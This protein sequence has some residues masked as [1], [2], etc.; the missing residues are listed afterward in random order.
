MELPGGWPTSPNAAATGKA[1]PAV[2]LNDSGACDAVL[3]GREPEL[4]NPGGVGPWSR[5]GR[6]AQGSFCLFPRMNRPWCG[7]TTLSTR[8]RCGCVSTA[9]PRSSRC[10]ERHGQRTDGDGRTEWV[11]GQETELGS[12]STTWTSSLCGLGLAS[13]SGQRQEAGLV[14]IPVPG[15]RFDSWLCPLTSLGGGVGEGSCYNQVPKPGGLQ[16]Q[17]FTLSAWRPGLKARCVWGGRPPESRRGLP[18]PPGSLLDGEIGS[19]AL[20]C[21]PLLRGHMALS[22]CVC[23]H[24]AFVCGSQEPGISLLTPH[25]E[26]KGNHMCFTRS[27]DGSAQ[28]WPGPLLGPSDWGAC[29]GDVGV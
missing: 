8:P 24:V 28:S 22:T 12:G 10:L 27:L 4:L 7:D 29:T 5:Q 15:A 21:T 17:G 20:R 14:R 23:L 26:F 11:S 19:L 25:S 13:W 2:F 3:L 1:A 18:V 16:P 9:P 6:G